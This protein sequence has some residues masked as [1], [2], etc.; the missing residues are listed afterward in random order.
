MPSAITWEEGPARLRRGPLSLHSLNPNTTHRLDLFPVQF[1][2]IC[3]HGM[4]NVPQAGC[5]YV[6]VLGEHKVLWERVETAG[7][8]NR[9]RVAWDPCSPC[10]QTCFVPFPQSIPHSLSD[11]LPNVKRPHH[12]S[13]SALNQA[14]FP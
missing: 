13:A 12:S 6:R 7:D 2:A 3:D 10:L 5:L 14:A 1:T 11:E 8:H 9:P 4:N